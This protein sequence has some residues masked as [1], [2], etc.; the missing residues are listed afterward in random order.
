MVLIDEDCC[1]NKKY[2]NTE[3]RVLGSNSSNGSIIS[4]GEEGKVT[5]E[6]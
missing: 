3:E 6:R 5:Q 4:I 2:I 1:Q